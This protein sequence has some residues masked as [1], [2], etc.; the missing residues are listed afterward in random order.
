MSMEDLIKAIKDKKALITT[1]QALLGEMERFDSAS[2][3]CNGSW[4]CKVDCKTAY[5]IIDKQLESLFE[6]LGRLE[7]AKKAGEI[8]L[9][10]WLNQSRGGS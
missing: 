6:E 9:E 10:G 5:D 8:T 3:S 1:H 2:I 7:E 4:P